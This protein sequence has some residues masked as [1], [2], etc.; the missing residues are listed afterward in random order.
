MLIVQIVKIGCQRKE[1]LRP[2]H[3]RLVRTFRTADER[4]QTG[5]RVFDLRLALRLEISLER[6]V[7]IA[8]DRFSASPRSR[9]IPGLGDEVVADRVEQVVVV[10]LDFAQFQEV[11]TGSRTMF[12]VEIYRDIAQG[13]FDN[14][15]HFEVRCRKTGEIEEQLRDEGNRV[16][17]P[18]KL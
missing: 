14:H 15:R 8:V 1:K 17:L 11:K 12:Q 7:Q 9:R 5:D 6:S 16:N 10:V 13:R 4:N 18:V 2:D 3:F